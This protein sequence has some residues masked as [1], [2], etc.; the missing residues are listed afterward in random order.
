MLLGTLVAASLALAV[1]AGAQSADE[2]AVREVVGLYLESHATGDGQH[3]GRAFH[4]ELKL[5]WVRDGVL[6]QRPGTEYVAGFRGTPPAD[7]AQ[8]R[9][10]IEMVDVSGSAAVAK[11]V[12]D[13]PNARFTDYFTLLK[14]DGA[15]KIMNK[16]FHSEPKSGG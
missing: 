1:P 7:E 9:R 6:N 2:A 4:P 14:I 11:V 16:T 8:R 13:Y 15:W 3:V 10:W 12:L 5:Y